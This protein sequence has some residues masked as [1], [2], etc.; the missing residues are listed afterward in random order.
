MRESGFLD[1]YLVL[2]VS[3]DAPAD[4]IRAAYRR[5]AMLVHPDRNVNDPNAS[6]HMAWV[7]E[8]WEILGDEHKRADFD[9]QRRDYCD[10]INEQI[11][12]EEDFRCQEAEYQEHR[13]AWQ[14]EQ[15][16]IWQ[17]EETTHQQFEESAHRAQE[18]RRPYEYAANQQTTDQAE[19]KSYIGFGILLF[20]VLGV[21][22]LGLMRFGDDARNSEAAHEAVSYPEQPSDLSFNVSS[23]ESLYGEYIDISWDKSAGATYYELYTCLSESEY[24]CRSNSKH[25]LLGTLSGTK[26]RYYVNLRSYNHISAIVVACNANGCPP[27]R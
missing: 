1:Y 9:R 26:Y 19:V 14:A 17:E 16:R 24:G 12:Y 5:M 10:A 18:G 8:A 23:D 7:N 11:E 2:N 4:E 21:V 6:Q 20:V 3:P 27:L 22:M 15:E 25:T 13:R